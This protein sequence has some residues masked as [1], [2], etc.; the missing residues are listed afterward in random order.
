MYRGVLGMTSPY[1]WSERN[2]KKYNVA[3]AVEIARR[4]LKGVPMNVTS[5]PRDYDKPLT[6]QE[7][8]E[9]ADTIYWES[10]EYV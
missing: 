2:V 9:L 6:L 3:K 5:V 1:T 7:V 8:N 4:R 10:M